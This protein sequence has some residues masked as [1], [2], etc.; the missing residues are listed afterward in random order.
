MSSTVMSHSP[1]P[2]STDAIFTLFAHD[3]FTAFTCAK[4]FAHSRLQ[5]MMISSAASIAWWRF[6]GGAIGKSVSARPRAHLHLVVHDHGPRLALG[7]DL[8][9]R[10]R[11]GGRACRP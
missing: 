6:C 9:D 2:G 5:T 1:M 7:R 8:G 3:S 4:R 11:R 10:V